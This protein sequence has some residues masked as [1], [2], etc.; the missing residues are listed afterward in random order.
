MLDAGDGEKLERW[1][2]ASRCA[3]RSA[4]DL[5]A[6]ERGAVA[7]RGRALPPVERRRGR[8]GIS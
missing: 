7:G 1:G 8:V 2:P 6:P 4:G 5:A 3:A